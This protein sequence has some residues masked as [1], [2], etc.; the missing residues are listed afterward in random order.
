[1]KGDVYMMYEKFAKVYD[2]FSPP[3][4]YQNWYDFL[5]PHLQKEAEMILDLGCGSGTLLEKLQHDGHIVSGVDT[6]EDMLVLADE[7]LGKANIPYYLYHED[8]VIFNTNSEQYDTIISTC[9][10]INYISSETQV[11]SVFKNV[12]GM[13][14]T[15][16]KFLF[17][18]HTDYTFNVRFN[19][20]SYAD[21]SEDVSV[22]WNTYTEDHFEYDHE[23]TF[24][25]QL[26]N[27]LYM[28]FDEVHTQYYY[29]HEKIK[30]LLTESGFKLL[31]YTTDF[32]TEHSVSGQRC[33]YIVCKE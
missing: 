18:I 10:S 6:S 12:Y 5:R 27:G 22:L 25:Q 21:A 29:Q 26:E 33:F 31:S 30:K 28:R 8:M 23:L 2:L 3:D 15:G 16:G 17:D 14:K 7:K 9:D 13:L 1:M 4:F 19:D 24:Y 11:Q 20:W 32:E